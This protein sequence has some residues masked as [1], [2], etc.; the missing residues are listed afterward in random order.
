ML[1]TWKRLNYSRCQV[2]TII[3][4][5]DKMKADNF[6]EIDRLG[7][8]KKSIRGKNKIKRIDYNWL[9]Q[10]TNLGFYIVIPLFAGLFLGIYV[11]KML[12]TNPISTLIGLCLGLFASFY[13]LTKIIR[14]NAGH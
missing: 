1:L 7:K 11:D 13:N 14:D 4:F 5:P 9:T 12:K 2:L 10:T 8:V 3:N 6:F